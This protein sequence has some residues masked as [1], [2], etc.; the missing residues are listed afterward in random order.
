[1]EQTELLFT[2]THEWVKKTGENTFLVGLTGYALE[3]LG[4]LVFIN[5]PHVG[6]AVSPGESFADVE[7]VKAVSD[8]ISPVAGVITK[9]NEE[10]IQAPEKMNE[11]PY[12]T[13]MV[14]M[15]GTGAE[16]L[17][18]WDEYQKVTSH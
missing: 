13:W 16:G 18:T 2:P 4:D 10:L 12:D 14:E 5:L 8:V 15:D 7:S 9:I 6:D 3:A 17:L 1:M 11:A